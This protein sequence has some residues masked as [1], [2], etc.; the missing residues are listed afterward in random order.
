[1]AEYKPVI[2]CDCIDEITKGYIMISLGRT[3]DE[4]IQKLKEIK[5]PAQKELIRSQTDN[6]RSIIR[7]IK[8]ID[9]C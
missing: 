5:E 1:M 4:Y 8:K 6:L 7:E 2:M 3:R 9:E